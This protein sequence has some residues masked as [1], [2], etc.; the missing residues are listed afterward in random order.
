MLRGVMDD[1]APLTE[2]L[3]V[4]WYAV[5]RIMIE[6]RAGQHDIGRPDAAKR[7]AAFLHRDAPALIRAPAR[8][9]CIPPT[10][11]TQMRDP[12]EMRPTTL[13]AAPTGTAEPDRA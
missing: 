9:V 8:S 10:P 4:R 1:V 11:V 7:E 6:V 12:A 13:F 3:E 5:A 2:S